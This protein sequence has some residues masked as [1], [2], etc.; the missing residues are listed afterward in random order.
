MLF[1]FRG[2]AAKRTQW[3]GNAWRILMFRAQGT[4]AGHG[5]LFRALFSVRR[6]VRFDYL[7]D[8]LGIP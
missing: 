3:L 4:E 1:P 5:A 7:G 2:K 6:D 8:Y